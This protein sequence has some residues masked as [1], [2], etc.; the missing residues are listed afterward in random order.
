MSNDTAVPAKKRHPKSWLKDKP[1]ES[2][3][4]RATDEQ[5]REF[6]LGWV[7]GRIFSDKHIHESQRPSLV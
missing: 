7:D 3:I 5:L 4:P 1:A 6:V 2:K